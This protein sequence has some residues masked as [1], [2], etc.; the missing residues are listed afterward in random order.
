[1]EFGETA[2]HSVL[3][4]SEAKDQIN[5]LPDRGEGKAA[6]VL[7]VMV[8][9]GEPKENRA[10][11]KEHGLTFQ[12]VLHRQWEVSRLYAMFATPV[13]YLI[14]EDG[15]IIGDVTVGVE[16]IGRDAECGASGA[17]GELAF[18]ARQES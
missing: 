3:A 1:M 8:S 17:S 9:R 10:K 2:D 6:P 15:A 12:V 4:T 16:P 14:G 18:R 5:A 7:V 11:V 13:A